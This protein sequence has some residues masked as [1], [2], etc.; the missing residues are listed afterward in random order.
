MYLKGCTA[1]TKRVYKGWGVLMRQ[2]DC[3]VVV[4]TGLLLYRQ[5]ALFHGFEWLQETVEHIL[6]ADGQ[7]D[8]VQE[9]QA[10]EEGDPQHEDEG[11][12]ENS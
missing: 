11:A 6:V 1:K 12:V 8:P 2:P 3:H 9:Q 4:T 5:L 10:R 7:M